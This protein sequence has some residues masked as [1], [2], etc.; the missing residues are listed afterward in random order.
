MKHKKIF[1][2]L[3]ALA[4]AGTMAFSSVSLVNAEETQVTDK[5]SFDMVFE[6][7]VDVKYLSEEEH[8]AVIEAM[9]GRSISELSGLTLEKYAEV[10]VVDDSTVFSVDWD[11]STYSEEDVTSMYIQ[12]YCWY[13]DDTGK[14]Q[15]AKCYNEVAMESGDDTVYTLGADLPLFENVKGKINIK[16]NFYY[17]HDEYIADGGNEE[18]TDMST[19]YEN[20]GPKAFA[21]GN[22]WDACNAGIG[23]CDYVLEAMNST[24][25][26]KWS[27]IQPIFFGSMGPRNLESY[28]DNN[29]FLASVCIEFTNPETGETNSAWTYI[30]SESTLTNENNP[31]IY[32]DEKPADDTTTEEDKK[33]DTTVEIKEV[34]LTEANKVIS[35]DDMAA[36]ITENATKDVVIKTPAG[37]TL[38]FAKGTM[39]AVDG[40]DTYDFGV[41]MSNDYSKHSDMGVVTKD[42]FVSL[43]DFNYSGNLPAEAT[44]KIPVG[45]E[46]A[47]QT[48]YYSQKVEA[49]YTLVQSVKVDAEGYI[50]VKQDHCST[51]VVTTADV[52]EDDVLDVPA[53]DSSY[54]VMCAI[55]FMMAGMV[56]AVTVSNK[57]RKNA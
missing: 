34:T 21:G 50:T 53:G 12:T 41:S 6:N 42:N 49:G 18:I 8:I 17:S 45:V 30:A 52:S 39:K 20:G 48:L 14:L 38:T 1:K 28:F 31:F 11:N 22:L 36:L 3:S 40:K 2:S 32:L 29:M 43:I 4:L 25:T 57:T 56:I 51:Y 13:K 7:E 24:D 47:G 46:R 10:H 37:I 5:S 35:K 23:Y 44:V 19:W 55:L 54:I 16:D 15:I 27:E 33:D 26:T 9:Y